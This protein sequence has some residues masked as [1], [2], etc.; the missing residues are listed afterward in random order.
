MFPDATNAFLRRGAPFTYD[1]MAFVVA[2]RD[3][4]TAKV[5]NRHDA[6]H[7]VYLPS[8]D[9]NVQDPVANDILV[10]STTKVVIVEGNYT[11]LNLDPWKEIASMAHE[12]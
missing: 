11:L 9:H 5:T 7:D 1:A 8:F 6:A 3:L 10:Q 2:V 4:R 12:R